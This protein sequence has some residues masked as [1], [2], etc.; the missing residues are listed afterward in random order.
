MQTSAT[1][2]MSDETKLIIHE[3]LLNFRTQA[4][5][6]IYLDL[7][8]TTELKFQ[9]SPVNFLKNLIESRRAKRTSD[10]GRIGYPFHR[11]DSLK[12]ASV[13]LAHPGVSLSLKSS[14]NSRLSELCA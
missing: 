8:E 2:G 13:E 6:P 4:V 9:M 1:D 5:Y 7:A 11:N 14:F 3:A 12:E 10:V